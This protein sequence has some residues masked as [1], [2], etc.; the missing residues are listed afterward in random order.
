MWV[1]IN[2][3]FTYYLIFPGQIYL[4]GR[5][6]NV[7]CTVEFLDLLFST[8]PHDYFRKTDFSLYLLIVSLYE[9]SIISTYI[10]QIKKELLPDDYTR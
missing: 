5:Q 6:L 8:I 2:R 7:L 1:C 3:K 10:F 9:S 4:H